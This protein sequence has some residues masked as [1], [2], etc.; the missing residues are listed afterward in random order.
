MFVGVTC[1]TESRKLVAISSC[2]QDLE[3][4]LP[5]DD[6]Y[7]SKDIKGTSPIRVADLSMNAGDVGGPQTV[8]FN[9]PNDERSVREKGTAQVI[10]RNVSEAKFNTIL[11]PIAFKVL[12]PDL[13]KFVEFESFFTHTLCHEV[14]YKI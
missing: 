13:I 1:V 7:K 11:L 5:M 4:L 3:D 10:W 9:L 2:L 8:A 12:H 14:R 6:K